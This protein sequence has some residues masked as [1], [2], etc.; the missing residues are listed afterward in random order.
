MNININLLDFLL[1]D[2]NGDGGWNVIDV[3]ALVNCVLAANCAGIGSTSD[4][5]GD[6]SWN[7]IDV[8]A[9]SNCILMSN[10]ENL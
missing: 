7:V 10:C 8:V 2:L 6:G 3:V 9:L 5:N 1:G 4:L